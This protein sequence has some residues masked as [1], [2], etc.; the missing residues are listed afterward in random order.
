[1]SVFARA[2]EPT[3]LAFQAAQTPTENLTNLYV[4][5]L[6]TDP[7]PEDDV[8]TRV[9]PYPFPPTHALSPRWHPSRKEIV[10]ISDYRVDR[11][12]DLPDVLNPERNEDAGERRTR[13]PSP[14]IV[15]LEN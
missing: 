1:V 3:L 14:W 9:L 4:L 8:V 11:W 12:S 7:G 6:G 10:Y 2:G 15:K 13:F 5:N